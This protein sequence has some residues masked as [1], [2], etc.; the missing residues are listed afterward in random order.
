MEESMK[1]IVNGMAQAHGIEAK[2]E[3]RTRTNMTIN[4]PE[5]ARFAS[6]VAEKLVGKENV[7]G[8]C[9]PK[10]FSEDFSQML[11]KKPGC[12]ILIGNG[13]DGSCGKTLHSSD[14]DF[15]DELLVTGSS[16]WSELVL[17]K[18]G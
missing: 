18:L 15:N 11:M 4:T 17:E 6:M 16:Y 5:Q 3:Y 7:D 14:Y 8:D 10:L 1:S 2:F 9:E 13:K 12:Y